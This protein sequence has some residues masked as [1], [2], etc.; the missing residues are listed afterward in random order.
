MAPRIF[1]VTIT[2]EADFTIVADSEDD[3]DEALSEAD[4][5]DWDMPPLKWNISDPLEGIKTVKDLDRVKDEPKAPDMGVLHGEVLA[6]CDVHVAAPD[7][8]K[9]VSEEIRAVKAK[10]AIDASN[11]KLFEEPGK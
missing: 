11:L 3:L 5:E 10:I 9:R 8:L 4:F 7:T 6:W 1:H 2:Q